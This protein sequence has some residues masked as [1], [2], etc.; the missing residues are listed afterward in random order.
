MMAAVN[1][2]SAKNSLSLSGSVNFDNAAEMFVQGTRLIEKMKK[3]KVDLRDL[4][5]CDSSGLA[6]LTGWQRLS[7][8]HHKEIVFINVP[9]FMQD[10]FR[11]YGLDKVLQTVWEN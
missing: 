5:H 10:I 1:L 11:V 3:V 7:L 6:L 8:K 2:D 4:L 9:A